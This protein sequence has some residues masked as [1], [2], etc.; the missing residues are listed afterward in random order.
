M[1]RAAFGLI[2]GLS[3]IAPAA[4]VDAPAPATILAMRS[5]PEHTKVVADFLARTSPAT[6][7]HLV[8]N[9]ADN[10]AGSLRAAIDEANALPGMALIEFDAAL[11]GR[12]E[13]TSGTLQIADSLALFGPGAERLT[14]D[15]GTRDRVINIWNTDKTPDVLLLGLTISGGHFSMGGGISSYRANLSLN[16]CVI[17]GNNTR[18]SIGT[19]VGGGV[20]H[21]EGSLRID[22]CV[23]RG[24]SAGDQGGGIAAVNS[25]VSIEDSLI[26]ANLA[27]LGGG[28]YIDTAMPVI[29]R[30]TLITGNQAAQRG[31]GMHL[32]ASGSTAL[33]ENST[34]SENLSLGDGGGG[35]YARGQVELSLSTIAN[36]HLFAINLPASAS[37]GVQFDD[38]AGTLTLAGALIAGNYLLSVPAD[39][40]RGSGTIH[41]YYSLIR[42]PRSCPRMQQPAPTRSRSRPD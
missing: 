40:G 15:G 1:Y 31:G 2:L 35:L 3:T 26:G 21:A 11:E 25:S 36:N 17:S 14:L 5:T 30:R 8:T 24:N 6:A 22:R 23:V 34:I 10:G 28:I 32:V 20:Y 9:L 13:L 29:L 12:I 33:I 19:E 4:A 27:D 18:N 38:P 37:G 16:D 42:A 41:A 7:H 39:L